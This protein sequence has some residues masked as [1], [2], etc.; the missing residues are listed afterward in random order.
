MLTTHLEVRASDSLFSYSRAG[1]VVPKFGHTIVER[2]RLR[3]QLRELAR[4]AL[5][6]CL[7]SKDVL[8]KA[9]PSAYGT[10]FDILGHEVREVAANFRAPSP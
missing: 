3:R 10:A 6:P 1:V 2:N 8:I 5:L 7:E 4:T 9:L